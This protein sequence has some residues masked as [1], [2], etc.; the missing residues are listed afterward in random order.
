MRRPQFLPHLPIPTAVSRSRRRNTD[1]CPA[2]FRIDGVDGAHQ[3][4]ALFFV[5]E[6]VQLALDGPRRPD[7]HEHHTGLGEVISR[8]V[9]APQA[10]D[11]CFDQKAGIRGRSLQADRGR[12]GVLLSLGKGAGMDENQNLG[13]YAI[14]PPQFLGSAAAEGADGFGKGLVSAYPLPEAAGACNLLFWRRHIFET[15]AGLPLQFPNRALENDG[16]SLPDQRRVQIRKLQ[17]VRDAY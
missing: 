1:G 7:V 5:T 15:D 13:G 16:P 9:D 17:G 2:E 6:Q 4:R 10:L 12:F 8:L 3:P 14:L 11:G